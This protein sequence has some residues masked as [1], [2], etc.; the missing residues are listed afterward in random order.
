M[1]TTDTKVIYARLLRRAL[2]HWPVFLLSVGALAIYSATNTGFLAVIKMVT[3]QGFVNK[4][5]SKLSLLPWM[6][7]G[8]LA[9]RAF[10]NFTANFS[11]RWLARR[12]VEALRLDAFQHLMSMPVSFFDANSVGVLTAKLTYDTEQ[13]A[14]AS[15]RVFVT[16]IRDTLTIFGMVGYMLFLDWRLTS[17]FLFMLPLIVLYMRNRT[18][19][20]RAASKE[21]Q[22]SMGGMTQAIE[23]AVSGQRVVKI[24]GGSAYENERFAKIVGLNRRMMIRLSRLSGSNSMVVELIAAVTLSA[25]VYY[26]VGKFSAGEFAAFI[27]AVMMLIMPIKSI[28]SL[29][30]DVQMGMAGARSVFELIDR[31]LEPDTGNRPITR[32]QGQLTFKQVTLRYDNAQRDALHNINIDI[33][34]GEKVALVGKSGGGKSSLVNLLPRF[35]SLQQGEILLD[36]INVRDFALADLRAQ[37]ALVSQEVVLFNDSIRN[38]IAYGALRGVSDAEVIQAAEA[39]YAWE[40][41][42][43][44]PNGLQSEIGDRGVR[45][46]GGQRQRLAIARAILKDAPILLLDEATSALDT[47]SEKHVQAALDRLMQN[48]TTLIIA[49]RLSTVENADR[50]LVMEQGG[51]VEQGSHAELLAQN[52]IYTALYRRQFQQ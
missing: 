5:P 27:S 48:R 46:S 20:V 44:L 3:D 51:I 52:G 22:V 32:S 9:T 45:L 21:V 39:A 24:F 41:I 31:E 25:V 28:T 47:E 13:V 12:V 15:T 40:F 34:A 35:Y 7:F 43:Q 16:I 36:G 4:D 18:P 50:I 6:M 23:E 29:N 14:N 2:K 8:L 10:A 30:E 38:N 37:F 33:R 17:V 42:Q 49:H 11:M 26:T 19:L 1:P